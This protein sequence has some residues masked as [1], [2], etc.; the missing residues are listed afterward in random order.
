MLNCVS[1]SL[2]HQAYGHLLVLIPVWTHI[3]CKTV[4][5]IEQLLN[6]AAVLEWK[7]P[8]TNSSPTPY[9][10]RP[11]PIRHAEH[12]TRHHPITMTNTFT[13]TLVRVNTLHTLTGRA[14]LL[15]AFTQTFCAFYARVHILWVTLH[16]NCVEVRRNVR[17]AHKPLYDRNKL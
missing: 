1:T 9:T 11:P 12:L 13:C 17:A 8:I 15:S 5:N 7:C 16:C 2:P 3:S 14:H 4:N 10:L 6:S